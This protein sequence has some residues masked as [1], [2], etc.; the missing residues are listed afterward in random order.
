MDLTSTMTFI[1]ARS[2]LQVIWDARAIGWHTGIV[3]S[4]CPAIPADPCKYISAATSTILKNAFGTDMMHYRDQCPAIQDE[5]VH[6]SV[7][8]GVICR[9][10]RRLFWYPIRLRHSELPKLTASLAKPLIQFLFS[11]RL[12]PPSPGLPG[13]PM[14]SWVSFCVW[15]FDPSLSHTS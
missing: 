6:Q 8:F 5:S 4:I 13:S 11:S 1:S 14:I 10:D 2:R 9:W 15:V 12:C 3:P 7:G